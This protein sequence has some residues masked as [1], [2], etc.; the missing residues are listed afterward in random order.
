M[1]PVIRESCPHMG[2]AMLLIIFSFPLQ[3]CGHGL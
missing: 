3:H 1:D 2:L